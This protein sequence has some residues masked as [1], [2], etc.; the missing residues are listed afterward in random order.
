MHVRSCVIVVVGA[1]L[2]RYVELWGAQDQVTLIVSMNR[3]S[4]RTYNKSCDLA[5]SFLSIFSLSL[6]SYCVLISNTRSP[7]ALCN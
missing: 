1:L 5:L 3:A 4:Y 6:H 7:R 2:F